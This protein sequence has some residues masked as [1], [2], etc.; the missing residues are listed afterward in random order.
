M[1][2]N[3]YQPERAEIKIDRRS[4][5]H[6]RGV[7]LNDM[8]I[9][10]REHAGDVERMVQMYNSI[11]DAS[12]K[13]D[14][15]S[16]VITMMLTDM[17]VLAAKIIAA[18]SDE[19]NVDLRKIIHLPIPAQLSAL[20]SIMRLTFAEVGGIKKFAKELLVQLNAMGFS[21]VPSNV[22][23]K[24]AQQLNK[25]KAGSSGSIKGSDKT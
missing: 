9:V 22:S 11:A 17:P 1:S 13:R 6:V 4:N 10:L 18:C 12:G 16:D 24:V 25:L 15:G 14:I 2:L 8:T 21:I 7:S 20:S 23:M 5:F 3:D 19:E